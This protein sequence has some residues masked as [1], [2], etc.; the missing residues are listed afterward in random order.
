[1]DFGLST[2]KM[3]PAGV[4]TSAALA[5]NAQDVL[6]AAHA[7][8]APVRVIAPVIEMHLGTRDAN[9]KVGRL[10]REWLGPRFQVRGRRKWMREHGAES[11]TYYAYIG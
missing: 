2:F 1:M 9:S 4:A 6:A 8:K 11:G 7:G 5:A 10:I 3:T